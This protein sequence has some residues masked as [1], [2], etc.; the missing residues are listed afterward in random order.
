METPKLTQQELIAKI[1]AESPNKKCGCG[2][3]YFVR[4]TVQKEVSPILSGTGKNEILLI[5]KFLCYKCG[6]E[7]AQEKILVS[8]AYTI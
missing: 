5:E 7:S 4:V 3:E 8:Y 6:Q 2:C 1:I